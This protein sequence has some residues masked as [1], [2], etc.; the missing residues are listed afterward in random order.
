MKRKEEMV[1]CYDFDDLADIINYNSRYLNKRI[2]KLNRK[3]NGRS[4]V[5]GVAICALYLTFSDA[6][7]NLEIKK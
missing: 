6:I 2:D 7:D 1:N 4:L 3:V 5:A